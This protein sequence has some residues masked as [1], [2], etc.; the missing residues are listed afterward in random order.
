MHRVYNGGLPKFVSSQRTLNVKFDYYQ[1]PID[2]G[3]IAIKHN[4]N[5]PMIIDE[6][7]QI[8]EVYPKKKDESDDSFE[9]YREQDPKKLNVV[10]QQF[11]KNQ[12]SL[13]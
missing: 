9:V 10:I 8:Q 1:R 11:S 3:A 2:D 6:N 13:Y 4:Q 5:Q 12:L 7:P